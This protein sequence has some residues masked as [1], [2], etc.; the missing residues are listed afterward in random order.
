MFG[1]QISTLALPLLATV[2]IGANAGEMA[3]L[4]GLQY[5]PNLV[6][7]LFA[8]AWVDRLRRRP[9]LITANLGR[10]AL[11]LMLPLATAGGWLRME[12]LYAVSVLMGT[13]TVFADAA[14]NAYLPTLVGREHLVEGNAKLAASGSATGIAGPGL[15]GV[16]IDLLRA[17]TAIAVD[18]LSFLVA[19]LGLSLIRKTE[20]APRPAAERAGIWVEIV[21]GLRTVYRN[22]VLRAFISATV[23]FDIFWNALFALYFLYTTREFGLPATALGLVFAIGSASALLGALLTSRITRVF[24]VGPTIIGAQILLGLTVPLIALPRWLP[25]MALPLLVLAEFILSFV[26]TIS[27]INRGS[28]IQLITPSQLLGRVW[29]SRTFISLGIVPVGAA[30]GGLLGG[31]IG[32]PATVTLMAFGGLLSFP[33]LLFSPVRHIRDMPA[34]IDEP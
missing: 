25:G 6:I 34:P 24:G 8:G 26:G 2:T 4:Y 31:R 14:D 5:L 3:T 20:P 1:S 17:P 11:L 23:T 28:L 19:A 32:V 12:L 30:L 22:P 29:A 21:E 18:G 16:L 15:A 27:A 13:M 33:W 9:V 7:G 10:G